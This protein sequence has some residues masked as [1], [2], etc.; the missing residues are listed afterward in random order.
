MSTIVVVKK[1]GR[2][3]I[4]ADT[5]ASWGRTKQS[6]AYIADMT[7][8]VQVGDSFLGITGASTH[9]QVIE[10]YFSR[11]EKYSFRSPREIFETWRE[12]H[13]ALKSD[14]FLTAGDD[15]DVP[16]EQSHMHVLL[17]NPH[18]IFGIYSLRSVDE[19]NKFWAFGSGTDYALGAL[20]CS[21]DR[22]DN[23]EDI[24]RA[25]VE[26][27]AEFDSATALPMT[28]HSVDLIAA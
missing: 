18:G 11:C 5:L 13:G 23:V 7:K 14:Y 21:Y 8:I 3:C 15:K 6:A 26:A 22:F 25:A 10:N 9:Q 2:V 27:A 28:V 12:F 16:Y 20:Y 1:N 24:A 4:A 17:A 19:Y